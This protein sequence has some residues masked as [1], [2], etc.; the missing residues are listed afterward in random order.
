MLTFCVQNCPHRPF[1]VAHTSA[2]AT[3]IHPCILVVLLLVLLSAGAQQAEEQNNDVI[4]TVE[5]RLDDETF[6]HRTKIHLVKK[7][8]GKQALVYPE[9]N[10]IFGTDVD[11]LKRMLDSNGL[12]TMRIQ[13]HVG[14]VSSAPIVSSIPAVSILYPFFFTLASPHHIPVSLY[15]HSV[16]CRSPVLR[17]R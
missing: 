9:K 12:Y 14:N 13:A 5:H 4:F 15:M 3:M 11:A 10:G 1:D 8:D 2:V 16:S 17:R 6:T 7:A